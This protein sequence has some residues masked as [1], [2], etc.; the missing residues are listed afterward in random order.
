MIG[1][2]V[3]AAA[4]AVG[5]AVGSALCCAGPLVVVSLGVSGAGLASTFEPLR[6]YFLAGTAVFLTVG[7]VGLKRAAARE[8]EEGTSCATA[9][10]LGRRR[11]VMWAATVL[12]GVFATYP[13]WSAWIL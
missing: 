1:R 5:A 12:A 10:A 4:G 13:T 8:C 11:R 9:R 2:T 6:P 3:G 7:H